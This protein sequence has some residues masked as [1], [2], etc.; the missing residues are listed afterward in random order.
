MYTGTRFASDRSHLV[1]PFQSGRAGQVALPATPLLLS[2][3]YMWMSKLE[4]VRETLAHLSKIKPV[5]T[6]RAIGPGH[7]KEEWTWKL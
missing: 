1:T 3:A 7:G 4:M 5:E 6:S 2:S